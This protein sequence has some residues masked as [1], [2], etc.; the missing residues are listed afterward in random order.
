MKIL[1]EKSFTP[2]GLLP[3]FILTISIKDMLNAP[4][5]V[6]APENNDRC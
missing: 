1:H 6:G 3:S 4:Q 2:V 5:L